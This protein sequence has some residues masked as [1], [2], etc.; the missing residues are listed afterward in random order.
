MKHALKMSNAPQGESRIDDTAV[1]NLA[2]D[3]TQEQE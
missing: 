2:T 1:V 3:K